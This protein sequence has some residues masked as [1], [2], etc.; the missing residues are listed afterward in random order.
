MKTCRKHLHV[1]IVFQSRTYPFFSK[2]PFEMT[3]HVQ[4]LVGSGLPERLVG[5]EFGLVLGDGAR[6]VFGHHFAHGNNLLRLGN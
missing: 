1:L 2:L 4:P 3:Y 5:G 6:L